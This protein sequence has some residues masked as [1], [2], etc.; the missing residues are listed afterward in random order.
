VAVL[1][2]CKYLETL[3]FEVTYLPVDMDGIVTEAALVAAVDPQ[4]TLLGIHI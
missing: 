4:K 2:T 1:E 3:G